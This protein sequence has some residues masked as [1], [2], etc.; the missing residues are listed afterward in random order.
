MAWLGLSVVLGVIVA[1]Q[2]LQVRRLHA[3]VET[4][5]GLTREA[6]R[7]ARDAVDDM[8]RA[9]CARDSLIADALAGPV[10]VHRAA[11]V[12]TLTATAEAYPEAA[13]EDLRAYLDQAS[14]AA[15]GE[16]AGVSSCT[17]RGV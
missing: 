10:T 9:R 2:A 16:R 14:D 11:D 7:L 4:H 12:V 15:P 13:V 3:I 8:R 1:I 5:Q 17:G 6:R